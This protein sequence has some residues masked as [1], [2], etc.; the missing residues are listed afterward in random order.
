MGLITSHD[1]T[2]PIHLKQTI[3]PTPYARP[4]ARLPITIRALLAA[5]VRGIET[6]TKIEINVNDEASIRCCC[7]TSRRPGEK[8]R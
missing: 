8:K 7:S 5:L 3:Q 2:V 1:Q 4:T 6:A